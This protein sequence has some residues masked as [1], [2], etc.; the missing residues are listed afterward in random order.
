MAVVK[1]DCKLPN[2]IPCPIFQLYSTLLVYIILYIPHFTNLPAKI[3]QSTVHI[4]SH[5][6]NAKINVNYPY[7]VVLERGFQMD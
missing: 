1:V 4:H 2:L 3:S 6:G 7:I 5:C